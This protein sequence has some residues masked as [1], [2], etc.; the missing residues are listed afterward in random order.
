MHSLHVLGRLKASRSLN[1]NPST[2]KE[3]AN[4]AFR[5]ASLFDHLYQ[6]IDYFSIV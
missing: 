5:C 3:K 6:L 2:V 4:E 1:A